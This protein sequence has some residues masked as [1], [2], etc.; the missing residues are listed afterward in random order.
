MLFFQN[1]PLSGR[2]DMA[3][4]ALIYPFFFVM[5]RFQRTILHSN[6]RVCPAEGGKGG[7]LQPTLL[8]NKKREKARGSWRSGHTKDAEYSSV[9]MAT[10][11]SESALATS[12][13]HM[14]PSKGNVLS[15]SWVHRSLAHPGVDGILGFM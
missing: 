13:S 10:A 4:G 7:E 2:V 8:R 5:K 6:Q 1:I 15:G 11:T 3:A 9:V 12:A 14:L